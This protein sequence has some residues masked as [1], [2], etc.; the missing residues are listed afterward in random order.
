MTWSGTIA[1]ILR[2]FTAFDCFAGQLYHSGWRQTYNVRK[3][4]SPSYIFPLLAIITI[5]QGSF[6]ATAELLVCSLRV[7][8]LLFLCV[9]LWLTFEVV[10]TAQPVMCCTVPQQLMYALTTE[11]FCTVQPACVDSVYDIRDGDLLENW[12]AVRDDTFCGSFGL[13]VITGPE[14]S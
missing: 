5:L 6:S 1:L 9:A 12:P 11:K 7:R 4:S 3:I 10:I 8:P 14:C 13:P 2:V